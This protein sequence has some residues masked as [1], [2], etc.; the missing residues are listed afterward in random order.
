M[1]KQANKTK[2]NEN[3]TNNNKKVHNKTSKQILTQ[4]IHVTPSKAITRLS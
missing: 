4:L 3:K 2:S 1:D